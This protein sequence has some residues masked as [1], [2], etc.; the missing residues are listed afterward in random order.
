VDGRGQYVY[1]STIADLPD[2]A[3]D[4]I[5]GK[6]SAAAV[7]R[8]LEIQYRSF[9]ADETNFAVL[10]TDARSRRTTTL[11]SRPGTIAGEAIRA[12]WQ[13][14]GFPVAFTQRVL[15]RAVFGGM[16]D[17][18]AQRL[19]NNLPH[20]A[21]LLS[22]MLVLGAVSMTAKDALR[23]WG[24]RDWSKGDTWAAAMLQSG[25]LGIYGDF[26]FGE[27]NRFGQGRL[28]S[29]AGPLVGTGSQLIDIFV[30]M[31]NEPFSD[32]PN[33]S[34]SAAK[35]FNF[36]LNNTPFVNLWYTRPA[37][38][39]LILNSVKEAM[40]PGYLKRQETNRRQDYGQQRM[41][42]PQIAPSL[43]RELRRVAN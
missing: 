10:E 36:A 3:F 20:I 4:A 43:P 16:G 12:F 30:A 21:G 15:G 5:R 33:Y 18:T 25:G 28:E 34:S 23:G 13:F 42:N 26:L 19:M 8:E 2:E 11:G 35:A 31:K 38:D 14:K 17:T 40:S 9:I 1:G 7:R 24:M 41:F 6:R 29:L 37:I 32:D 22:G 39:Y 27:A